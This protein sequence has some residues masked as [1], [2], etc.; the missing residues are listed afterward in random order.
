MI[1][2]IISSFNQWVFGTPKTK[3]SYR[4]IRIGD[5]L[6]SLLKIFHTDQKANR[7]RYG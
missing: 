3:S 7:L 1:T 5:T 2:L 4:T 6:T